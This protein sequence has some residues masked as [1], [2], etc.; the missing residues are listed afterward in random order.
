MCLPY[1]RAKRYL[2]SVPP[3]IAGQHGDVHTFRVCCRLVRGFALDEDQALTCYRSGT[4]VRPAVDAG[5][6]PDKL[7]RA[8]GMDASQLADSCKASRART[9]PCDGRRPPVRFSRIPAFIGVRRRIS[10]SL[11]TRSSGPCVPPSFA[12]SQDRANFR[13]RR[14]S[15]IHG[16][17]TGGPMSKQKA[18]VMSVR[19]L[20]NTTRIPQGSS[21]TRR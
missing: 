12:G 15:Q 11:R 6:A 8:A 21:P 3:A 2:T 4:R 13:H 18:E 14:R 17:L 16:A 9:R 5:R 19:I 10:P 7:H 20:P 1:E